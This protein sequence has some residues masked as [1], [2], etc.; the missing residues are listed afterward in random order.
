MLASVLYCSIMQ[1]S[2]EY[3]IF[4]SKEVIGVFEE[5]L[6][7]L[8]HLYNGALFE[9]IDAYK[10]EQRSIG[11]NVQQNTLPTLKKVAKPLA[12]IHSQVVQN[13]LKRLQLAYEN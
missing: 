13:C 6:E 7:T 11:Y 5:T 1:R 12:D 3:K 4:P 10:F 8:R 2:F 9:R